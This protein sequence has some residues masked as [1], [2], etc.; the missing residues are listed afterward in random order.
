ML[1]TT[2]TNL[3]PKVKQRSDLAHFVYRARRPFHP[4][5]LWT[6]LHEEWPDVLR[7]K[8]FFWLATRNDVGGT[9]S[10]AGGACRHGPAGIWWAAQD[11]SE[12]PTGD[13]EL[14]A[15]IAA[16][17]Y[18]DPDD[19][20]DRRPSSGTGADRHRISMPTRGAA[21][22]TPVFSPMRNRRRDPKRWK[23]F[24]IRSPHGTS[25][26]TTHDHDHDRRLRLRA[27][28]A[29]NGLIACSRTRKKTRPAAAA[30]SQ[31]VQ[32]DSRLVQ[33]AAT[34]TK[35]N[36]PVGGCRQSARNLLSACSLRP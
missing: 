17:W 33:L 15:E 21:S 31:L 12:W 16:D 2:P 34:Q 4:E 11:R 19:H 7:S 25:T 32:L 24:A 28:H 13:A 27:S 30:D 36:P 1:R 18:G 8:G 26:K 14:E 6:L 5:R 23:R 29:L 35:K 20:D 10:Q 22:S 3:A 9:L